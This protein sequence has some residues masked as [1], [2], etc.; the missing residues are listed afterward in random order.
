[1]RRLHFR[2]TRA[3]LIAVTCLPAYLPT[4]LLAQGWIDPV[5][6]SQ[7][8]GVK[9]VS[10]HV[11]VRV[12]GRIASVEVDEQ[13]RNDGGQLGES[14]YI[15][16]LPG[17]AVFS[18]FSLF[19]GEQEL[20][21]ETMNAERARQIYE[22]IVRRKRD[23]ALIE[24][25]GHGMLRARVFPIAPGETRRITL[26]YTQV[27]NRSG[28]A[29]Q[30][31]YAAGQNASMRVTIENGRTFGEPFSPT[32]EVRVQRGERITVTPS[33]KFAG[34]FD[35]FLPLRN[36]GVGVTVATHRPSS[37]DGFF[38]LTL[39]PAQVTEAAAPRDITAVVDVSGSMSGEKISQAR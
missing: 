3:I 26:R 31:K 19:Q 29:L 5:R 35:L 1:M 23:P 20:R 38:M 17:E 32:H 8:F 2:F 14:D 37:E 13:F 18:N 10:T 33:G 30:F 28:D 12:N 21:G 39:S 6:P 16:P 34:D 9:K 25:A 36:T 4:R 27:L 22:E 24:L 7:Q 15:Y 11:E